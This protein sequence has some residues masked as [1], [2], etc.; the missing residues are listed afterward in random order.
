[1]TWR[2]RFIGGGVV[3]HLKSIKWLTLLGVVGTLLLGSSLTAHATDANATAEMPQGVGSLENIFTMPSLSG[4][5]T[6]SAKLITSTNAQTTG[7]PAVQITDAKNQVGAVWSTAENRLDLSHDQTA[8]MWLYF[9]GTASTPEN[10]TGDGMAFVLQNVGTSAITSG[11]SSKVSPGQTLGVWGLDTD[12]NVTDPAVIAA[13]AIQKSWALEFDEYDNSSTQGGDNGS[14]DKS[15][16]VDGSHIASNYPAEASTYKGYGTSSN[17]NQK[18]YTMTHNGLTAA[19]L[20]DGAWHHLTLT[21][22]APAI[23]E[24]TG[25]MT[26]AFNDKNPKTGLS[27]PAT[28]VQATPV[29][30][31]KLGLTPI[32][33]EKSV[34]NVYWGFT[35]ST[36]GAYANNVVAFDQV[37]GLV[38]ATADL[39]VRDQTLAKTLNSSGDYV[40]GNDEL[41]YT[42]QLK[43]TG[44]QQ[45]WQ[46]IVASLPK[47]AG[48]TFS[49]GTVSYADGT[50]ED[51]SQSELTGS[52]LT[53]RLGRA[54]SATNP[55]ATVTLTGKA[56]EVTTNTTVATANHS[57][58]GA[59]SVAATAS[60][61][62][63]IYPARQLYLRLSANNGS[64]VATG[65]K[66]PLA[67]TVSID[68]SEQ[69]DDPVTNQ[70]VTL[71]TTL[72]NGNTMPDFTLN[73]TT[74][75]AN[76]AGAFHFD[77]P[78]AKLSPGVNQVTMYATDDRGQKS[79]T[80]TANVTLNGELK[81]GTVSQKSS[82]KDTILTGKSQQVLR[83]NDWQVEVKDTL[84]SGTSWA[85]QAA[86]SS[87]KDDLGNALRGQVIYVDNANQTH[88]L[89]NTP[90]TIMTKT[91]TQASDTTD[92]A[93]GWTAQNGLML[94]LDGN[95][96]AGS[97]SGT[98]TW[99]L[100]NSVPS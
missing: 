81:F 86:A 27:Q 77:L 69:P 20:S 28:S 70:D 56:D 68:S 2:N 46:D 30:M 91:V 36:G 43:Y 53:H 89:D 51:W 8:S 19:K 87:F 74:S 60:P 4:K 83:Q 71:H 73:G 9:G 1:M 82:F 26:Y 75:N 32:D 99:T 94:R 79:N 15:N 5:L 55:T 54:L 21:W 64:S 7:Q 49:K 98:I 38:N 96:V 34:R 65:E 13:K 84:G 41:T 25:T 95:A 90:T 33:A 93:A 63:T 100:T 40:N 85:L 61:A 78:A 47:P 80:V 39:T 48:V 10:G 45:D 6:N 52:P 16:G 37:P 92:V 59:N 17:S 23:G 42:Y 31:A 50:K 3:V 29:D 58:N 12:K 57:F 24:T 72:S 62:Y 88:T 76:E 66:L 97:Y 22:Q 67:G 35:G 14:L 11:L 44:G 18:Y